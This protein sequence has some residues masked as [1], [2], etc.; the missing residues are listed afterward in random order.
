ME[1]ENIDGINVY[2]FPLKFAE[3]GIIKYLKEYFYAF[4]WVA[5]LSW[6]IWRK[7]RFDILHI[8]NP[9]DI[10]FPIGLFYRLLGAKF[11]FDHHD[12]FP[13]MVT[14]RFKGVKGKLLCFLGRFMEY[15]TFKSANVVLT[16]N[17]SYRQITQKRSHIRDRAYFC[18]TQWPQDQRF[19][20]C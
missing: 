7:E 1:R 12:L 3:G 13:E 17:E 8:C 20:T 2:R 18:C 5:R 10:F 4:I 11:V 6:K 9:P 15:M 19:Q 16:T 14:W